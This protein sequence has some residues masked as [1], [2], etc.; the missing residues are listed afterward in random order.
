MRRTDALR[1]SPVGE[2]ANADETELPDV[3]LRALSSTGSRKVV[4]KP[5]CALLASLQRG[6]GVQFGVRG[7]QVELICFAT[8]IGGS[9]QRVRWV[10]VERTKLST[11]AKCVENS[12][13]TAIATLDSCVG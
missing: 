10:L 12:A 7:G 3:N 9:R 11:Q 2:M 5:S 4:P 8:P 1:S 13:H 6:R